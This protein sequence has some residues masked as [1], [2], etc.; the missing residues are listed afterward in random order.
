[1]SKKISLEDFWKVIDTKWK[2]IT[3]DS[4]GEVFIFDEKPIRRDY[5]GKWFPENQC[6]IINPHVFSIP[7][8]PEN[9]EE[10]LTERPVDYSSM[11]GMFGKFWSSD[12][13]PEN[14]DTNTLFRWAYLKNYYLGS[15][16]F[17]DDFGSTW[18]H[19]KPGLPPERIDL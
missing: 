18:D 7:D 3:K 6:Y 1:M 12:E 10:S 8:L 2:Y 5:N 11:I 17:E 9:W 15:E 14:F 19:F 16:P 4:N 13:E